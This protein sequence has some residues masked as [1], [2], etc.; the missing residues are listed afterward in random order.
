MAKKEEELKP[1]ITEIQNS[2]YDIKEVKGLINE[3]N[4]NS[5]TFN[6]P[7]GESSDSFFR[8]IVKSLDSKQNITM[9]TEYLDV[10]ENF[11]GTKL[12]FLA[13]Y[14]NM[15][16]LSEFISFFEQKRVSLERKGRKEKLMALQERRQEI[17][18]ERLKA[19]T[20]MNQGLGMQ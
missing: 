12:E 13:K 3:I 2:A 17:E 9:N 5:M 16:Y 19:L 10:N 11:A 6:N 8:N 20:N 14:G 15:P 1:Q 18:Q 7:M 4:N